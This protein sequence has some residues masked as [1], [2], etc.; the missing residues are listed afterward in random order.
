MAFGFVLRTWRVWIIVLGAVAAC[1]LA[2]SYGD[3]VDAKLPATA[4]ASQQILD[5]ERAAVLFVSGLFLLMV[6]EAGYRGDFP[7]SLGIG[8]VSSE[9]RDVRAV[10]SLTA[11]GVPEAREDV[12]AAVAELEELRA[13]YLIHE[14]DLRRLERGRHGKDA[15]AGT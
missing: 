15:G 10:A 13:L 1:G 12:A 11:A 2:T 4:L 3:P 14:R 5:V 9:V 8:G 7:R 6:A